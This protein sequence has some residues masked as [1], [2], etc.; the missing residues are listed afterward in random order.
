MKDAT[1]EVERRYEIKDATHIGWIVW[2]DVP[3]G[4]PIWV[5]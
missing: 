4:E 2:V 3:R 5:R 1:Y